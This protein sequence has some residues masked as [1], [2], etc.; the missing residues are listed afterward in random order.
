M[1]RQSIFRY[2]YL[3]KKIAKVEDDEEGGKREKIM[4]LING[5]KINRIK[6][7]AK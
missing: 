2:I 5:S 6:K 4:P 3:K 1:N 7:N